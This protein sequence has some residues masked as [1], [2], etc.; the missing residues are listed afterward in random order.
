MTTTANHRAALAFIHV[1]RTCLQDA[2]FAAAADDVRV[3]A[4]RALEAAGYAMEVCDV[5]DSSIYSAAQEVMDSAVEF[6]LA[7]RT[8]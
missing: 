1:A 7:A 4:A 2:H 6:Q 5:T 3:C 8:R